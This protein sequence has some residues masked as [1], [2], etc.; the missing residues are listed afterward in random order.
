MTINI[1]SSY[2]PLQSLTDNR[3]SK[4]RSLMNAGGDVKSRAPRS[5]A[6]SPR[7]G[8]VQP[9]VALLRLEGSRNS[10]TTPESEYNAGALF[11]EHQYN[12]QERKS[13]T[14]KK[15]RS[16]HKLLP[17]CQGRVTMSCEMAFSTEDGSSDTGVTV[18]SMRATVTKHQ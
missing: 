1:Y 18:G 5:C 4:C 8:R 11:L 10:T 7:Y 6:T 16:R 9:R 12:N 15:R 2:R 14:S 13:F 17:T 3:A